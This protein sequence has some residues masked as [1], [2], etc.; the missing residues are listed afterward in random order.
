MADAKSAP[1]TQPPPNECR[2]CG[3]VTAD[4]P[5]AG[6]RVHAKGGLGPDGRC[7]D[8]PSC[9]ESTSWRRGIGEWL[10][11][12]DGQERVAEVIEEVRCRGK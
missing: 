1:V 8:R 11:S 7:V 5:E 3:Q 10:R 4:H 12:P 2:D 6:Y 9:E